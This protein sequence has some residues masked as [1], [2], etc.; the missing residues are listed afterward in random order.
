MI[1]IL[2]VGSSHVGALKS[3]FDSLTLPNCYH[4]DYLA[5]GAA[6]FNLFSVEDG[7]I[8][9]PLN[10]S[11]FIRERFGFTKP[12]L[13]QD[14]KH[15]IYCNG[16]SRLS[17][18]LFSANR[19]IPLLSKSAIREIVTNIDDPLYTQICRNVSS[20]SILYVG[21]PLKSESL[22][23]AHQLKF[24]PLLDNDLDISRAASLVQFIRQCCIERCSAND[25]YDILLPPPHVLCDH[26]FNTLDKYIRGGLR[27]KVVS[28]SSDNTDM[29]HGNSA[30][31]SEMSALILAHIKNNAN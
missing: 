17:F 5:L 1:K 21:S 15:I 23:Q 25:P 2:V 22:S 8:C 13:I 20:S 26:Q 4:V 16:P 6:S 31:G 10:S 29:S 27:L 24:K 3:G 28:R 9:Y 19:H 18:S 30:Y 11:E 12:P 7:R 14:Y